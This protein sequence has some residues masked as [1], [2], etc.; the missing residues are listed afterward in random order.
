MP[1]TL[2]AS[3]YIC[4]NKAPSSFIP[5]ARTMTYQHDIMRGI[6]QNNRID[7]ICF[8]A[9]FQGLNIYNDVLIAAQHQGWGSTAWRGWQRDLLLHL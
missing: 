4:Q 5:V 7:S 3:L 1:V 6:F 9:L 8:S 2:L